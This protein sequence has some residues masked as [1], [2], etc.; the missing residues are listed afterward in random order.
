VDTFTATRWEE[1]T[2]LKDETRAWL[3]QLP[4]DVARAIAFEN[5][6]RLFPAQ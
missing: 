1:Y 3:T 6:E 2:R 4:E 5:G